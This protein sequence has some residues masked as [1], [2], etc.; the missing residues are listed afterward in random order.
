MFN[1]F[2]VGNVF[3][4]LSGVNTTSYLVSHSVLK[5]NISINIILVTSLYALYHLRTLHMLLNPNL[6]WVSPF[7]P[8]DH[9]YFPGYQKYLF[10]PLIDILYLFHDSFSFSGIK[11]LCSSV[12]TCLGFS[13]KA[14]FSL[15]RHFILIQA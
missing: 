2:F 7:F 5:E 11:I 10:F 3:L 6:N 4:R 14:L 9:M 13:L 1:S 12:S 8:Q 15:P